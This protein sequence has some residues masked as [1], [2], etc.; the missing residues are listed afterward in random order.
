[1]MLALGAVSGYVA[2]TMERAGPEPYVIH[3]SQ[4]VVAVV[5]GATGGVARRCG[6]PIDEESRTVAARR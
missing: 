3:R 5:Q 1:V 4:A 2:Y 6:R